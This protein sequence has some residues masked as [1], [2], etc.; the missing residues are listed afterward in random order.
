MP[1]SFG[2]CIHRSW[3]PAIWLGDSDSKNELGL[4][5]SNGDPQSSGC[6]SICCQGGPR[7]M[8]LKY[9]PNQYSDPREME[10]SQIRHLWQ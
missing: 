8:I 1:R 6:I 9:T 4:D 5:G 3:D 7:L 2:Y 10:P